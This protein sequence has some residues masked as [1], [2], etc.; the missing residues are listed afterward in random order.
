MTISNRIDL[1]QES[2][3]PVFT[4]LW[5]GSSRRGSGTGGIV[6]NQL[7]CFSVSIYADFGRAKGPLEAVPRK[8][9]P[10]RA[11]PRP[12][13]RRR[14]PDLWIADA[15]CGAVAAHRAG[16]I[17]WFIG[18]ELIDGRQAETGRSR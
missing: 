6:P 13:Q 1:F 4:Q 3:L 5:A 10:N 17:K 11:S 14:G 8:G 16:Q 9:N 2:H 18:M 15:V 7:I 12:R